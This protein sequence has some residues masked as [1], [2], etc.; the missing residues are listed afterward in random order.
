MPWT[1]DT[2]P[3]G[4]GD[5][6][7]ASLEADTLPGGDQRLEEDDPDLDDDE[8]E[9]VDVE[10]D[11][12]S[13]ESWVA[14]VFA[15]HAE[16]AGLIQPTDDFSWEWHVEIGPDYEAATEGSVTEGSSAEGP[17]TDGSTSGPASSPDSGGSVGPDF[18]GDFGGNF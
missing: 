13:H 16:A 5:D 2:G 10:N 11:V 9:I 15:R 18:G 14:G 8:D 4:P 1:R 6:A 7:G 3:A 17:S 12:M